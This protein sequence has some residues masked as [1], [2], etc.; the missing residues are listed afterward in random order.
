MEQNDLESRW[1]ELSQMTVR[2][3]DEIHRHPSERVT[4]DT[5]EAVL[6]YLKGVLACFPEPTDLRFDYVGYVI[7]RMVRSVRMA[8]REESLRV[9]ALGQDWLRLKEEVALLWADRM[10][11]V[12]G[13]RSGVTQ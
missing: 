3:E 5:M 2:F 4:P 7:H 9:K 13:R 11:E 1:N 6:D 8:V 12:K 10:N